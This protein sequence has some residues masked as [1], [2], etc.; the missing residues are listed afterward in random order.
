MADSSFSRLISQAV[1][2]VQQARAFA[3]R[4]A[5][6]CRV[7]IKPGLDTAA[8]TTRGGRHLVFVGD[9]VLPWERARSMSDEQLRRFY[10]ALIRHEMA[11][12]EFT[13]PVFA[14]MRELCERTGTDF[15]TLNLLED[16]R[17]EHWEREVSGQPFGWEGFVR[18]PLEGREPRQLLHAMVEREATDVLAP[19]LSLAAQVALLYQQACRAA[20]VLD[21]EPALRTWRKLTFVGSGRKALWEQAGDAGV[22]SSRQELALAAT[23]SHDQALSRFGS[24]VKAPSPARELVALHKAGR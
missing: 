18:A 1:E 3:G 16:A 10:A 5:L 15:S 20:D 22:F 6:D 9:R 4:P 14:Q 21:L 7:L 13:R 24:D 2:Q 23:L 17:V 12:A 8:W 19:D 11:H